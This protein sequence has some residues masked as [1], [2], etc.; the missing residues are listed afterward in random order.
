M[1]KNSIFGIIIIAAILIIWGVVQSPNKKELE[2]RKARLDSIARIQQ[3][4]TPADT[5]KTAR[6]LGTGNT[7]APAVQD[8][9][10]QLQDSLG[11]FASAV[12]GKNEFYTIENDLIKLIVST[13]GGRP[14][15]VQLKKYK[16]FLREPVILFN[17]DS[18]QFGLTFFSQNRNISTN[19]LYFQPGDTLASIISAAAHKDSLTMRLQVSDT[20]YIEYHYVVVPGS[21]MINFSIT[22]Q[23]MKD[24]V[25][26]DPSTLDLS[27]EI[28]VPQQEQLKK[29]ENQYT[30]IYYR[31][32]NDDVVSFK[33]TKDVHQEEI[34]TQVQWVAFKNQFFSSVILADKGF[35]NALLKSTTLPDE[36]KYLKNFRAEIGL[37]FQRLDKE[38]INMKM[39][40]GPVK[41]KL[42]RQYKEYKLED[43]V[44]LGKSVIRWI[45]QFVIIPIFDWLSKF[46]SNYGLIIL[47][48]T[49]IIKIGL[50][51][52]TYK[53][54]MSQARMKVLKPQ[55]DELNLKYPKGKEVEKQ[56]ATMA[57]YKKAGVSPMGGCLPMLLQFPILFA[58]FR[59]F[60]TSIELRQQAFL[61]AKDLSTYDAIITWQHAIPVMGN[62]ISLFTLLMTVSTIVSMKMSDTSSS[63]QIPGMKGMMYI[64]PVMFMFMLNNFSAGLTYYYFLANMIT[65]G[66]NYLF[67]QFVDEK[68]ILRKIEEKKSKT[69]KKSKF[70]Q[71]LED[72]AKQQGYRKP[73]PAKKK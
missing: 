45:N 16:T 50:L 53:S 5:S 62:H 46:M 6:P 38:T 34:P 35:S 54:Y 48:L 64:M 33:A 55:V 44:S 10:Q 49:V 61:W 69:V 29:N 43:L 47:L 41:F 23:G 67:K 70:Q 63:Q 59:F 28:N 26:R 2:A 14:Y 24:I 36:N 73:A 65:I 20:K 17:G 12:N 22:L 27:W 19:Q 7:V 1:D 37:P 31:H 13:K 11:E 66:Q 68:E 9:T 15:S 21:Y 4:Q 32:Y 51:P 8:N 25:T 18:T 40:F 71:R 30:S 56:Q 60:P 52:L 3:V 57:L 58:M 39:F 42:L 72:M